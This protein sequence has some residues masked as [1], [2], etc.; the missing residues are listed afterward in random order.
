[1]AATDF[2]LPFEQPIFELQDQINM[3]EANEHKTPELRERIRGLRK[4]M[5]ET[6]KSIYNGLD[7]WETVKVARHQDRPKFTDYLDSGVRRV[8]RTARR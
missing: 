1:M 8:R 4:Q 5:T 3:L 7:P 6:T 2:R